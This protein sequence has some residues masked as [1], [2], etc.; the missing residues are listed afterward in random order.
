M[1]VLYIGWRSQCSVLPP[2]GHGGLPF[3]VAMYEGRWGWVL[4]C[5]HGVAGFAPGWNLSPFLRVLALPVPRSLERSERFTR[6]REQRA[7][8]Q[9][10]VLPTMAL[11][12]RGERGRDGGRQVKKLCVSMDKS[13]TLRSSD[14]DLLIP[15]TPSIEKWHARRLPPGW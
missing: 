3:C 15:A 12:L 4:S 2:W 10:G 7:W 13:R 11:G 14:P 6:T 5:A 9:E 8:C 1:T